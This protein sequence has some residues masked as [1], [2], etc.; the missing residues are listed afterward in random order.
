MDKD[1]I[2]HTP[3]MWYSKAETVKLMEELSGL[4]YLKFT[5]T[6]YEGKSP[7]CG[8]CPACI[9]RLRGFYEAGI[10]DPIEYEYKPSLDEIEEKIFDMKLEQFDIELKLIE[11]KYREDSYE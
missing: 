1:I 6:C 9:I 8:K 7:A 5:H 10:E 11:K 3:L 2:I 4:K